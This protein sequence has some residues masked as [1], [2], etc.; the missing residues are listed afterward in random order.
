ME[1][2]INHRI[3]K[4][5][6][7]FLSWL[8]SY[9]VCCNVNRNYFWEKKAYRYSVVAKKFCNINNSIENKTNLTGPLNTIIFNR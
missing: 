5:N 4:H 9:M 7:S 3:Y 6:V 2:N 1:Y 8:T